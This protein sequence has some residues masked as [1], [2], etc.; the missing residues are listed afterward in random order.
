MHMKVDQSQF[1]IDGDRLIHQPTGA[2]FWMGEKAIVNCRWGE[3]ELA[4]GYD[5][6]R[7][8]LLEAARQMFLKSRST[9]QKP[10]SHGFA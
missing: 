8:E 2:V 10:G 6:D 9:T 7:A 1:T 5:Y 4:S 3:T